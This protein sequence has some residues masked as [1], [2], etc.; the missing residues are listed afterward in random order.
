M[1]A[2]PAQPLIAAMQLT[3]DIFVWSPNG[4][5]N[6]VD[7][8]LDALTLLPPVDAFNL[9]AGML[10]GNESFWK[11]ILDDSDAAAGMLGRDPHA[12]EVPCAKVD[13]EIEHLVV[14]TTVQKTT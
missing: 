6:G 5:D 3:L 14:S 13:A 4:D 2:T 7:S 8:W 10:R 1:D 9:G 12:S 11:A